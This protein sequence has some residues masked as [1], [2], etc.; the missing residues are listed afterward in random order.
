MGERVMRV[1]P[2]LGLLA[3]MAAGRIVAVASAAMGRKERFSLVLTGGST[4]K[5]LYRLLSGAPWVDRIDW[6]RVDIFF[7]DER[8]VPPDDPASNYGMAKETMLDALPIPGDRIHRMRGEIAPAAAAAEYDALLRSHFGDGGA[9][10]LLLGLGANAHTA[11]LFPHTAALHDTGHRAVE[12]WVGELGAHRLTMTAGFIN[13]AAEVMFLVSGAEKAEAVRRVLEGE[14]DPESA[15]AR[16]IDPT[17]GALVWLMD[18][19]AAGM[20]QD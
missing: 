7:G 4:P 12:N 6:S 20:D 1:L 8:C 14:G 16:L 11:S 17:D 13:R 18:T 10:M 19:M 3:E 9:D 5:P 2:T 15:P